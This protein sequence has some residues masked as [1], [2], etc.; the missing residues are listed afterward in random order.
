MKKV[1]KIIPMLFLAGIILINPIKNEQPKQE[2]AGKA[3][4]Y[5]QV[6]PGGGGVG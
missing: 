6:D 5:K 1:I 4:Q 2:I 3:V